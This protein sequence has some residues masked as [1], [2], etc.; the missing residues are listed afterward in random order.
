MRTRL[1]KLARGGVSIAFAASGLGIIGAVGASLITGGVAGATTTTYTCK[2]PIG[3]E[4]VPTTVTDTI[5]QP[6][7]LFINTAATV[8]PQMTFTVPATLI[9]LAATATPTLTQLT[10]SQAQLHLR[11]IGFTGGTTATPVQI[12]LTASNTPVVVPINTTT[13]ANGATAT[14]TYPA[15]SVT[16]TAATGTT[17]TVGLGYLAMHVAVGF[18]C[19]APGQAYTATT[20]V[21]TG[22]SSAAAVDTIKSAGITPLTLA[23]AATTALTPGTATLLYTH[24]ANF[25]T[26]SGGGGGNVW[27]E[28]GTLDGLTFAGSGSHASLTGT[29]TAPGTFGFTVTVTTA[30]AASVTNHYSI[31]VAT[32]PATPKVVQPFRL[33]VTPGTLTLT[34]TSAA[35]G[36]IASNDVTSQTTAKNCTLITLGSV[37]LNETNQL[38]NTVGHPLIISTARGQPTDSWALYAVMVPSSTTLTGNP[39]CGSVQGFCNVTTTNGTTLANHFTNTS[40][41]PNYLGVSG[42]KCS[43]NSTPTTPYYN[44]N[45][46]PT[47][48]TGVAPGATGLSV[49]TELCSAAAGSAGGEFFA[50]TLD[51]SLIVPPNVY[52]GTYYGTVQYTLSSTATVVPPNVVTPPQ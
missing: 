27:T 44:D 45:P 35:T 19:G 18:P 48:T 8:K 12:A 9:N 42:Q 7:T 51:Y 22:T 15:H 3:T 17:A 6:A 14:F 50:T 40:I 24:G 23:P 39:A 33:T 21:Y 5:T 2:T 38:V 52:A 47:N 26:A 46:A 31:S 10:A 13:K 49:Q 34:C 4:N 29:P 43:P 25:W 28:T 30:T 1:S 41:T 16:M 20:K 36:P 11:L 32:A 37:K